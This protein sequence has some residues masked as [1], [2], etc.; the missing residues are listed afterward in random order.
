MLCTH[1]RYFNYLVLFSEEVLALLSTD[2]TTDL[3][4]MA[5]K[6]GLPS[7]V[8]KECKSQDHEEKM[9]HVWSV[10]QLSDGVICKGPEA[11]NYCLETMESLSGN[12]NLIQELKRKLQK[13]GGMRE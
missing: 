11:S 9:Q 1:S 6:L 13:A 4:V 3:D 10:W 7:E 2:T 8:T 5:K 12:H